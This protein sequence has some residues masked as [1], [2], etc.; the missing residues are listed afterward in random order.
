MPDEAD[1][2]FLFAVKAMI[3]ESTEQYRSSGKVKNLKPRR[4]IYNGAL[5]QLSMDSSSFLNTADV[6]GRQY[7]N[8]VE[9]KFEAR[10]TLPGKPSIAF[11]F[12]DRMPQSG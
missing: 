11:V 7:Q 4:S 1:P 12:S 3:H 10:N 8:L 9:S 2:G 6:N 5:Y